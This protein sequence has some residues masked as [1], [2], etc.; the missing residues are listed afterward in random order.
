MNRMQFSIR[1]QLVNQVVFMNLM[2]RPA[3][4]LELLPLLTLAA[5][6][7]VLSSVATTM[8]KTQGYTADG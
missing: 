6:T 5:S 3:Q 7:F 8:A 4:E 2:H 1:F